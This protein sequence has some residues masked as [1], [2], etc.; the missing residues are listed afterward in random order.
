MLVQPAENAFPG[1]KRRNND[2]AEE[3]ASPS[4]LRRPGL[5]GAL[6]MATVDGQ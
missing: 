6:E 1:E 4:V 3:K 2:S 5:T